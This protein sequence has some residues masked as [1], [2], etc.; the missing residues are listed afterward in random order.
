MNNIG[1]RKIVGVKS[2]ISRRTGTAFSIRKMF[3]NYFLWNLCY[4]KQLRKEKAQENEMLFHKKLGLVKIKI[5]CIL[6]RLGQ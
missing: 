2:W 6:I 5:D 3:N 4:C 1:L